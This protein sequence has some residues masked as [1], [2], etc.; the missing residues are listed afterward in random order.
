[1]NES[2]SKR[3]WFRYSLRT[4]FVLV[5]IMAV[6]SAWYAHRLRT[7]ELEREKLTGVWFVDNGGVVDFS[8]DKLDVGM[9]SDGIGQIDFHMNLPL[10]LPDGTTTNLSRAIYRF[11]GEQLQV[12]QPNPGD[13]R[14]KDFEK[15]DSKTTIWSAKRN[16]PAK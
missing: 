2:K 16:T 13:P 10:R 4:L 14:P 1:M 6:A 7:I 5:T 8:A 12:A 9:P 3:R 11:N 15:G